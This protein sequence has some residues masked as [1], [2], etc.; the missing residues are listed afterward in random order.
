MNVGDQPRLVGSESRPLVQ[1][2]DRSNPNRVARLHALQESG[3]LGADPVPCISS[4]AGP[5]SGEPLNLDWRRWT[6]E[7]PE[8]D[9]GWLPRSSG[10]PCAAQASTPP[11]TAL[12]FVKPAASRSEAA[13]LAR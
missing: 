9:Y 4:G 5:G 7:Q 11:A 1:I 10:R 2:S 8:P 6:A 12:T 3:N 13:T